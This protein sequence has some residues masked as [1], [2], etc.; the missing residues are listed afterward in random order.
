MADC[1][2]TMTSGPGF[3]RR[4]HE[5]ANKSRLRPKIKKE[6]VELDL[7]LAL[8]NEAFISALDDASCKELDAIAD[9][10]LGWMAEIAVVH[11]DHPIPDEVIERARLIFPQDVAMRVFDIVAQFH[12]NNM[13]LTPDEVVDFISKRMMAQPQV[14]S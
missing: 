14:A 2:K 3:I 13:H 10:T 6:H 4:Q 5:A 9:Q 8:L 7:R 12:A 11:Q 1:K